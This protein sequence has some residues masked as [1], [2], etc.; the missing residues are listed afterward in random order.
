MLLHGLYH[1]HVLVLNLKQ[2]SFSAYPLLQP[3]KLSNFQIVYLVDMDV[4]EFVPQPFDTH[5]LTWATNVP[6]NSITIVL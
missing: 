4:L 2:T 3:N 6:I 1:L 5:Q